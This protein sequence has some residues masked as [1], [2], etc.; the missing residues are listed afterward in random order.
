MDWT[1]NSQPRRRLHLLLDTRRNNNHL[2]VLYSTGYLLVVVVVAVLVVVLVVAGLEIPW[3]SS[4]VAEVVAL[5]LDLNSPLVVVVAVY[6]PPD[7]LPRLPSIEVVVAWH[8]LVF[9]NSIVIFLRAV[10]EPKTLA[11]MVAVQE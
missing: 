10:A 11:V 9:P 6:K 2:E 4:P 8:V 5:A 1:R 7:L 3:A